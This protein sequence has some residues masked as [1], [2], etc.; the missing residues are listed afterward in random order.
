[1]E[2]RLELNKRPVYEL[3]DEV[4]VME[5]RKYY[6]KI[7]SIE[8]DICISTRGMIGISDLKKTDRQIWIKSSNLELI[9]FLNN[10][11]Y[12]DYSK[13]ISTNNLYMADIK[14]IILEEFYGEKY[15]K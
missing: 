3:P 11:N 2:N 1:M 4:I 9:N 14:K 7:P 5:Y 15:G 8:A 6:N 12:K 13:G 10:Y